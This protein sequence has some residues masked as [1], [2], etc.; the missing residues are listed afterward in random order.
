MVAVLLA[1]LTATASPALADLDAGAG[2][3]VKKPVVGGTDDGSDHDGDADSDSDTS[4]DEDND[5]NDGTANNVEDDG[6]DAHPS[7]K[8]R[9]V[10]SGGSGTQGK[11][12]SN[13]DDSKGPQR[14][15]GARGDDKAN[16]PGGT[17]LADQDGNN[18]CGNDDD[19]DDDNNGHC[20]KPTSPDNSCSENGHNGWECSENGNVKGGG[21][22]CPDGSNMGNGNGKNCDNGGSVKGDKETCPED[23]SM[24]TGHSSKD[25]DSDIKGD[26]DQATPTG[27]PANKITICHA[28]GSATNPFVEIT[29]SENGLSGHGDHEG[30]IIPMP[31]GGCAEDD[32][33]VLGRTDK[34]CPAGTDNA[35]ES[36]D[37][38]DC[39]KDNSVLGKVLQN[40]GVLGT[41]VKKASTVLGA[42]LPFTGN[43]DVMAFLVIALALIAGGVFLLLK[44]R[45]VTS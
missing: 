5:T 10:E 6:D 16:G 31:A 23:S 44:K 17:D 14:Y 8:D 9:S 4:Y 24:G 38:G 11:S 26:K 43:G 29:I 41:A 3:I 33:E 39:D 15:E 22:T 27:G 21:E 28:T 20:G 30:D 25:C 35:G 45:K 12:E 34:V 2:S 42:V 36:M 19:F 40:T 7:G 32:N 1:G 37:D 13:P 18:G